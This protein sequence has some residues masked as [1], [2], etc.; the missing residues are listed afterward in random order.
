MSLSL[1]LL[2]ERLV[3]C[4]SNFLKY[5]SILEAERKRCHLPHSDCHIQFPKIKTV[6]TKMLNLRLQNI[7]WHHAVTALPSFKYSLWS[8][9]P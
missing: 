1:Q 4:N 5:G 7:M 8:S 9:K 3:K 6:K 2:V